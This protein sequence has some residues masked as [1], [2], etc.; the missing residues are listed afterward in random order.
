MADNALQEPPLSHPEVSD[1]RT[2]TILQ[3]DGL[4][5]D[6]EYELKAFA[7]S[8]NQKYKLNYVK[9]NLWTPGEALPKP[10]SSIPEEIRCQVDGIMDLKL[11]VLS[12]RHQYLDIR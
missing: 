12:C 10:W 11:K 3:A 7:P 5:P 6:D 9:G 1:D 8:P 4:Y 2:I